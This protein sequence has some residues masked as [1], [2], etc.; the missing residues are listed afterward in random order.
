MQT[1][2]PQ[3]NSIFER[4]AEDVDQTKHMSKERQREILINM[5]NLQQ[6][7]RTTKNRLDSLD[8]KGE[9]KYM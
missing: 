2:S 6:L 5:R 9:V 1:Q 8:E 4:S 7:H 3:D